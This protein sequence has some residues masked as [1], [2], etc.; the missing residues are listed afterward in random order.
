MRHSSVCRISVSYNLEKKI[1]EKTPFR[2][3]QAYVYGNNLMTWTNYTGF[4]PEVSGSVL[5]PGKDSSKYP[6]SREIG[7]GI[8]VGL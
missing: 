1:I 3:V 6:H 5:T 7:F 2:N 4:D 8:N